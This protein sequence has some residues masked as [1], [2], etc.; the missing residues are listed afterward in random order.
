MLLLS[1]T[2]DKI[3]LKT[4]ATCTIVV[5]A[6]FNDRNQSTGISGLADKQNTSITTRTTTDIV[7]APGATTTRNIKE[8]H[9]RNAHATASTVVTVIFNANGTL[10]E[11]W[12]VLLQAGD[13]LQYME[14]SGFTTVPLFNAPRFD[15]YFVVDDSTNPIFCLSQVQDTTYLRVGKFQPNR[16]YLYEAHIFFQ[17]KATT[18]GPNWKLTRIE[19]ANGLGSFTINESGIISVFTTS[20][21]AAVM[22]AGQLPLQQTDG[23]G[24]TA[25][26][27]ISGAFQHNQLTEQQFRIQCDADVAV[28]S[29]IE[30]KQGS[31]VHVWEPTG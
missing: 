16:V 25:L 9:I 28:T 29:Q 31:W 19:P 4:D 22:T 17:C 6:S 21:T 30:V 12:E 5:Q 13:V 23:A 11:V 1:A 27:I 2:T 8:L 7:A 15:K 3:Q 24:S 20:V 26:T 18:T 10:Y 14:G